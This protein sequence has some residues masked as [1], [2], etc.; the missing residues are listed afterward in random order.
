MKPET[1]IERYCRLDAELCYQLI[2]LTAFPLPTFTWLCEN[3]DR[4]YVD[5]S[6][7]LHFLK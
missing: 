2:R 5:S 4:W 3:L 1:D 7:H 6:G